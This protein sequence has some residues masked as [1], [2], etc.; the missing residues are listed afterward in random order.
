MEHPG[1]QYFYLPT[2]VSNKLSFDEAIDMARMILT[3]D[4]IWATNGAHDSGDVRG[5]ILVINEGLMLCCDCMCSECIF[6]NTDLLS[7]DRSQLIKVVISNFL[8]D[9]CKEDMVSP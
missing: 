6:T 9:S 2:S 1:F 7:N 8:C 5:Y 3:S 4:D